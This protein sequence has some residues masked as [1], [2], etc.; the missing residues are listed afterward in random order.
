MHIHILY[1]KIG[2]SLFHLYNKSLIYHIL[3]FFLYILSFYFHHSLYNILSFFRVIFSLSIAFFMPDILHENFCAISFKNLS[4]FSFIYFFNSSGFIFLYFLE[5]VDTKVK[6]WYNIEMKI[7]KE[8]Y[9]RIEKYFPIQRGNVKIDNY[10]F[11]NAILYIAENGCKWRALPEKYGKWNSVYQRFKRWCEKG[12]IQRI[13]N[14]LQEEKIISMKI[15]V[16]ALDSTACKLHP[17]AHG[18]LKKEVSNLSENPKEDGTPSF[19]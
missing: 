8:Q 18:A 15:K 12:V 17:D 11:I 14:V 6:I 7:L 13:F 4:L 16:L 10:V 1:D 3:L 19:M 2:L 5:P 9:E